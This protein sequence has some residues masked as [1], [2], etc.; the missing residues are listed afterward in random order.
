MDA[1][2]NEERIAF[3]TGRLAEPALR[4]LLARIAP[5]FG[6]EYEVVVLGVSVAALLTPDLVARRLE[7]PPGVDRVLL[8]GHCAGDLVEVERRA[9]TRVQLGPKDLRQLPR[10]F[11]SGETGFEGP[12]EDYGRHRLEIVAEINHV[13]RLDEAEILRLAEHYRQSGADI[14]DLGC[15]PGT[16]F[17]DLGDR[18]KL[19]RDEGFRVAVDSFDPYEIARGAGAGAELVLSIHGQNLEAARD[20][21]CEVVVIPDDPRTLGGL[22]E[23]LSRLRD[24]KVK[25]RLDPVLEPIGFGFAASLGRYLEVRRRYPDSAILMGIGNLT[26]L[27]DV[28]TSGVNAILVGFCEEL[29]ITSVLTTEVIP[30]ARSAVREIDLARRLMHYAVS[31][32]VLP[33]HLDDRLLLLRDPEI[34]EHGPETLKRLAGELRDP[35]FRLFAEGGAI[36]AMNRDGHHQAEDPFDLFDKLEGV[37]PAHSFY[38]GYEMAK[39]AIALQLG[40]Q[41]VQDQAL[42]WG[43]LSVEEESQLE[44]KKHRKEEAE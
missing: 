8:P 15:D 20:L 3:V 29:E 22:D 11:R 38:L 2:A 1:T 26:E 17:A 6:F 36:H 44:K 19:L 13:P 5:D 34:L 28:D 24:W 40:K 41:Y 35:N 10:W 37:D 30:W 9:G 23:T 14:V 39:A 4:D 33:K 43:F 12:P 21:D 31:A 25:V 7:L 16:S 42:R 18:V 27:T 32:K